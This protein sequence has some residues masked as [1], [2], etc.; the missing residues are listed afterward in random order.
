M[1]V[2]CTAA[3]S[4]TVAGSGSVVVLESQGP[5]TV[6]GVNLFAALLLVGYLHL[7]AMPEPEDVPPA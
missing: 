5:V 7:A 2:L 4:A 1:A 3:F 6:A